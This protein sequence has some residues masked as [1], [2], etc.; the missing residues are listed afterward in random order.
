MIPLLFLNPR[1][2][3]Q[4]PT[5]TFLIVVIFI[6]LGIAMADWWKTRNQ[7]N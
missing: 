4:H 1:W 2:M 3:R 7:K 6:C 5:P